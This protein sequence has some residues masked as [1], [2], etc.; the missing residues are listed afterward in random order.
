M[1]CM[2]TEYLEDSEFEFV[3]GLELV[4]L[5]YLPILMPFV[6]G[7]M[8]ILMTVSKVSPWKSMS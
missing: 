1:L 8:I 6:A 3:Y 4:F 5:P 7:E 2:K